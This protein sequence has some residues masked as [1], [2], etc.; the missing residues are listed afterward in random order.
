[1]KKRSFL[2]TSGVFA[3][4]FLCCLLAVSNRT[5]SVVT[6]A[7]TSETVET[8]SHFAP[9]VCPGAGLL[10]SEVFPNPS[11]GTDSPFEFIE[12]VATR[13]IDF[14]TTP[15]SVVFVSE[16]PATGNGWREGG[17]I[18]YGF[19]ITTGTVA[20]GDV[21]YVGGSAMTPTGTKLRTINTGTTGGDAFGNADTTGVLGNGGGNFSRRLQCAGTNFRCLITVFQH[22]H[23]CIRACYRFDFSDGKCRQSLN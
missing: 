9:A 19:N 22:C 20:A 8:K 17:D 3:V 12:L 5:A 14:A 23:D 13:S 4:M 1:M 16:G 18:T 6:T 21:V 11:G 7:Q 15:H 10:I 2:K